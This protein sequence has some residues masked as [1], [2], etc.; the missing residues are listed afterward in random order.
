MRAVF[1]KPVGVRTPVDSP[2]YL[3]LSS[4]PEAE[5]TTTGFSE[6]LPSASGLDTGDFSEMTRGGLGKTGIGSLASILGGGMPVSLWKGASE[7]FLPRILGVGGPASSGVLNAFSQDP[8]FGSQGGEAI[9]AAKL[10]EGRPG[11][12][13]LD[14]DGVLSAGIFSTLSSATCASRTRFRFIRFSSICKALSNRIPGRSQRWNLKANVIANDA[15]ITMTAISTVV[16]ASCGN[17]VSCSPSPALT[18][19]LL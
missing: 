12:E 1:F 5:A 8:R 11:T 9:A 2:T 16:K 10:G 13:T 15:I 17:F 14:V 6:N 3:G 4:Q 18:E 19:G 7:T